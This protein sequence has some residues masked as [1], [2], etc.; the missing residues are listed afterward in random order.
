MFLYLNQPGFRGVREESRI[1]TALFADVVGSTALREWL[2]P[3]EVKLVVGC[4]W[5]VVPMVV[6]PAAGDAVVA[7]SVFEIVEASAG[8]E[9]AVEVLQTS[10]LPLG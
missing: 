10:A 9:P 6:G 7:E 4:C 3:E 8:L 1:V 2:D 5:M